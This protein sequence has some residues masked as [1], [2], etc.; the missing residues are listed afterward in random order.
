MNPHDPPL[1][2]HAL[3]LE[4]GT[5]VHDAIA[6]VV[7]RVAAE[8]RELGA[9]VAGPQVSGPVVFSAVAQAVAATL[10]RSGPDLAV[11]ALVTVRELVEAGRTTS[12]D[13]DATVVVPLASHRLTHRE[14]RTLQISAGPMS[15]SLVCGLDVV[16]DLEPVNASVARGR[17]VH[18]GDA[19]CHVTGSLHLANREIVRSR[20]RTITLAAHL[21]L[22]PGVPLVRIGETVHA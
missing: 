8:S 12:R 14:T 16:F 11:G 9:F 5:D 4:T 22:G 6:T 3:L 2:I 1:P 17:L 10:N 20:P 15:T 13:P 7:A 19:R 18:L 21:R